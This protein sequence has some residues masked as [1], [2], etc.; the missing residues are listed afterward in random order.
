[1]ADVFERRQELDPWRQR[2]WKL[3]ADTPHL[4][5]LLLTK[6]P[7]NVIKMVPRAWL[8][9]WPPN[10]WVGT[11]VEDQRYAKKRLQYLLRIPAAVRFVSCEPLLGPI[12]LAPHLGH[13]EGM[14]NWVIAGGESGAGCRPS[15]PEWFRDLR[16]Q[17]VAAGVPFFFK[18]W[19][20]WA[21]SDGSSNSQKRHLTVLGQELTRFRS[22]YDSGRYLDGCPWDENPAVRIP[23]SWLRTG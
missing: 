11:T 15:D 14:V 18:Q 16:D 3:I 5:W 4:D 20:N 19:G 17:C 21:P 13:G 9:N 8:E 6:R 12:N 23:P 10:V 7:Q 1:M 22:K 2:L